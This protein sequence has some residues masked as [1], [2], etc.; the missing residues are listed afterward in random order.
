MSWALR[1][2]VRI[3]KHFAVNEYEQ[4]IC[5][6]VKDRFGKALGDSYAQ[7]LILNTIV[8]PLYYSSGLYPEPG[9][10]EKKPIFFSENFGL[11]ELTWSFL[12][13]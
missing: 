12:L 1:Y 5:A 4:P 3:V 13:L 7:T 11:G 10:W 8:C 2:R 6:L 9:G